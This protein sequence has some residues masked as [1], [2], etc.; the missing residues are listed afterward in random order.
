MQAR[1]TSFTTIGR[2]PL[3]PNVDVMSP[4]QAELARTPLLQA[5]LADRRTVALGSAPFV[6]Y[7]RNLDRP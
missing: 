4:R 5:E 6:P 1:W 2:E 3:D 7:G